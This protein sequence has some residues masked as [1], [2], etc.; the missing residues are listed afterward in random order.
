MSAENLERFRTAAANLTIV[1]RAD[2]PPWA[3]LLGCRML[4]GSLASIRSVTRATPVP[5]PSTVY[6]R[7]AA[8]HRRQ[9]SN[10]IPAPARLPAPPYRPAGGPNQQ[11]ILFGQLRRGQTDEQPSSTAPTITLLA[12]PHRRIHR[13]DH[14]NRG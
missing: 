9:S 14:P 3:H 6:R 11:E 5:R 10:T 13:L 12:W 7:S 8:P 4:L 2:L 1:T